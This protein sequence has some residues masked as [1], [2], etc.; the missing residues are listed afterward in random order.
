MARRQQRKARCINN[1]KILRSNHARLGIHHCVLVVGPA[2]STRTKSMTETVKVGL[3]SL[4]DVCIGRSVRAR[5]V[6]LP[7]HNR[8]QSVGVEDLADT[9]L[10]CHG[11][12]FIPRVA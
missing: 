5:E 11:D 3:D 12:F 1:P 4:Q 10:S 9:F 7:D 8:F 2:H 6:F